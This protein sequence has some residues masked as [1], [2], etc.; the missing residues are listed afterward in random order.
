MKTF[1]VAALLLI[2]SSAM[3][4]SSYGIKGGLNYGAT[5][6]YENYS[7]VIGDASTIENGKEKTGYH[8]G[9]YG[10]LEIVGIF[11]QPEIVYTKLKTE[12][13]AF[14]YNLSKIDAPILLGINLLGP[15]HIKA[16]PS[17][18]YMLKNEIKN[19]TLAISEVENDITLGYQVGGGLN[20][21]RLGL[22][23]RYEGAFKENNAFGE[24]ASDSN[25]RLDSRPSQWI[26]SL[27]YALN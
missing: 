20:L 17:F 21:G 16:G 15:L 4:Q 1:I 11:I 8:L 24:M 19:S 26:L 13:N 27:S 18:Q 9:F 5:G 25:F 7:Q 12:Y 2:G 6:E 10:K 3:A 14:D 23:L 22:D